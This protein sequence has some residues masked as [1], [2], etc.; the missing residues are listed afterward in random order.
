[1]D[2]YIKFIFLS[3]PDTTKCINRS[4]KTD[5]FSALIFT[6]ILIIPCSV[7]T[8]DLTMCNIFS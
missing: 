6:S 3:K 5:V 1:M 2:L 8:Y 4:T 7:I